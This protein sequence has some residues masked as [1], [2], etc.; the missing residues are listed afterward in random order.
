MRLLKS[1]LLSATLVTIL[2]PA[3]IAVGVDTSKLPPA[4]GAPVDFAKDIKPLLEGACLKCHGP[5]KPKGKFEMTTRDKALKGG[6]EGVAIIP[7]DSAKSPL[8]HFVA[9]LVKDMEM[10][11]ED[12]GDPLTKEQIGLLRAWID[13]G[14]K[15]PDGHVLQPP[16]KK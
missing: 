4:A 16:P 2:A 8:I 7:G 15:W 5:E 9:R 10:P 11:P 6:H 14:V 13:Q 12:K 1:T 3:L